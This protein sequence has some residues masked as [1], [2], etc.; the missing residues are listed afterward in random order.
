M[1]T[2][3]FVKQSIELHQ[4]RIAYRDH[5][6]FLNKVIDGSIVRYEQREPG[7]PW[8]DLVLRDQ[9]GSALCS[10]VSHPGL[11]SHKLHYDNPTLDPDIWN[12]L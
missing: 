5:L 6:L 8:K 4:D 3:V 12:H 1:K 7:R 9:D 2:I 11:I 10:V